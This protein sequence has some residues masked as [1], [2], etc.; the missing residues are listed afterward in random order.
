VENSISNQEFKSNYD[1]LVLKV[2]T[3]S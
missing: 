3:S 2:I 1:P